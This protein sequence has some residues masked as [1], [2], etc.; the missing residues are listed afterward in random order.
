MAMAAAAA[1]AAAT[2]RAALVTTTPTPTPPAAIIIAITA[3]IIAIITAPLT[4]GVRVTMH[5]ECGPVSLHGRC[6]GALL[7]R[8][9]LRRNA[10]DE[11]DLCRERGAEVQKCR[12]AEVVI[13]IVIVMVVVPM[14]D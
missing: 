13:V 10:P 2:A 12:S 4:A 14:T 8:H 11:S 7:I 6:D 9:Q 5:C 1:A 3:I